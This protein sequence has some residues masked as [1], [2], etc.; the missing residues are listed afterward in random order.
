VAPAFFCPST[1]MPPHDPSHDALRLALSVL[2]FGGCGW[3]VWDGLRKRR[4]KTRMGLVISA[5]SRPVAFYASVGG[6]ALASCIALLAAI[7]VAWN[8]SR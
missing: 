7:R 5:E 2:V 1:K 3:F 4:V 6:Y 8:L